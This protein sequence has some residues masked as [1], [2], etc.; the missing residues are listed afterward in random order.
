MT[1]WWFVLYYP[2]VLILLWIGT[3]LD[4]RLAPG[5]KARDRADLALGCG[6]LALPGA[7]LLVWLGWI[8]LHNSG[9]Q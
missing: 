5:S 6:I 7:P 9:T 1:W 8:V 2:I 3:R 4:K